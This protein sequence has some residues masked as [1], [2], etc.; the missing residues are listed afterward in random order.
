MVLFAACVLVSPHDHCILRVTGEGISDAVHTD[1]L[2]A[3]HR[4]A[5][6]YPGLDEVT[7]PEALSTCHKSFKKENDTVPNSV[8]ADMKCSDLRKHSARVIQGGKVADFSGLNRFCR[9]LLRSSL[10]VRV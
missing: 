8:P 4:G 3:T 10:R 2:I 9:S 7:W 5:P 1:L 6:F